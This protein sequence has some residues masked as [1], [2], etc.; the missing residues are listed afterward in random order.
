MQAAP[1][2]TPHEFFRGL[3]G[4]FDAVF[5]QLPSAPPQVA[6]LMGVAVDS[7]D[8]NV[9]VMRQDE[10]PL[11]C[12]RGCAT[13]CT[14]RVGATAP[15]VLWVAQFLR[16][17]SPKLLARGIDLIAQVRATDALTQGAG[18]SQR[19][20]LRQPCPFVARGVCVI[21]DVRPL[22]CRGHT[23]HDVKACVDA[24]A[25]RRAEVP[26]SRSHQWVRSMVQNALQ[27]SVRAA[28][29]AWGMYELNQAVLIAMAHPSPD[30]AWRAGEDV[31]ASAAMG[32]V[33]MQE[34]ADAFDQL[35]ML[36]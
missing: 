22:A 27:S 31:F 21:Y 14:L 13:C 24:A 17:V 15:E 2:Q 26:F 4:A 19:V 11:A 7:F 3:H 35:R 20:S 34:M 8:G 25:G 33:P 5:E 36:S 16:A 6:A 10:P 12:H 1:L 28:G 30:E 23:S 29:L 32:D 9:R 18:E